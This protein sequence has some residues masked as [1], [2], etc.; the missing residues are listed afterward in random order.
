MRERVK[1]RR[2][3]RGEKVG[4][5]GGGGERGEERLDFNL[6]VKDSRGQNVLSCIEASQILKLLSQFE[7]DLHH[8]F[9]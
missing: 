4:K 8:S 9:S 5:T 3:K 7:N 1:A 6:K 2:S